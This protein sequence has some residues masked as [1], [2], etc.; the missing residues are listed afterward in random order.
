MPQEVLLF[1]L[2]HKSHILL[3]ALIC[4]VFTSWFNF[5]RSF[6]FPC[7]TGSKESLHGRIHN[8]LQFHKVLVN[9]KATC[10]Y[11]ANFCPLLC[12]VEKQH[13][14]LYQQSLRKYYIQWVPTAFFFFTR[15]IYSFIFTCIYRPCIMYQDLLSTR[16]DTMS[17][18]F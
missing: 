15:Y 18:S 6:S 13:A 8:G 4:Q 14:K 9:S 16:K 3:L 1:V 2:S 10:I 12:Q 17:Y 5:Q 11:C 7:F